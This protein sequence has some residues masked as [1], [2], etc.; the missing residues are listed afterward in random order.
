[1]LGDG[2]AWET[3]MTVSP[4]I[5]EQIA[6]S[7]YTSLRSVGGSFGELVRMSVGV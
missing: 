5:F 7:P 3:P 4:C 1:M 6:E 2:G